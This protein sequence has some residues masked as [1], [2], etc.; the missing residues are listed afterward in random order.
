VGAGSESGRVWESAMAEEGG[1]S[2]AAPMLRAALEALTQPSL[3]VARRLAAAEEAEAL[4]P[5]AEGSGATPAL[6]EEHLS[7]LLSAAGQEDSFEVK[8][9]Q[10]RVLIRFPGHKDP[11]E[12]RRWWRNSRQGERRN[13]GHTGEA[14]E[15]RPRRWFSEE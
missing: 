14:G 10:K 12:R 15:G 9:A 4:M 2:W 7:R 1:I 13:A 3:G 6:E 11:E 5:L 8:L